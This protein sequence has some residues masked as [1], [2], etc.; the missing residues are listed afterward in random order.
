MAALDLKLSD[1]EKDDE[2]IDILGILN[3]EDREEK[4][5]GADDEEKID[6]LADDELDDEEADVDDKGKKKE[7][8]DE[9]EDPEEKDL[10]LTTPARRKDILKAY[11]DLFKKFPYLEKAYY[12]E[13]AFTEV[14]PT[15]EDAKETKERA[16]EFDK[17]EASLLKGSSVELL[18]SVK[19]ADEGAFVSLV[20]NYLPNLKVADKDAFEHIVGNLTREI[21]ANM[22]TAADA[23]KN[24]DLKAAAILL[25]RFMLGENTPYKA[26]FSYKNAN[27][28]SAPDNKVKEEETEISKEK[29]EW[30]KQKYDD[31]V[32]ALTTKT[33]SAIKSTIDQN[34]D[35]KGLL[36]PFVKKTAVKECMELLDKTISKDMRFITT[37][38]KLWEK[39]AQENYSKVSLDN[40]RSAYISKAKTYLPQLISKVRNEALKG[41]GRG[42]KI[43]SERDGQEPLKRN[44][45]LKS[46]P[47]KTSKSNSKDDKYRGKSTLDILNMD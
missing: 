40:I 21:V 43:S 37:L 45:E 12:R 18:K 8:I 29:E 6:L 17:F 15:I 36:T 28:V 34:I 33:D 7:V 26:P 16:Q 10:E 47:D 13:Q 20:D 9:K 38:N 11:P 46:T 42:D 25:H 35:T 31:A 27:G 5:D 41:S 23:N 24:E 22:A 14:N 32:N 39:A 1:V 44:K 4:E 19:S 2:K 3:E 30:Q